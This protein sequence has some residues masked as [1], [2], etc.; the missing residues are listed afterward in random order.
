MD[1]RTGYCCGCARNNEEKIKWKDEKTSKKWKEN[2]IK[3]IMERMTDSQLENFCESYSF[4]KKNGMSLI[5]FKKEN[6]QK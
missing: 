5:K 3:E 4:K 1:T 2:N 6:E